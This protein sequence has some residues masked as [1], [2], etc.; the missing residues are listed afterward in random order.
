MQSLRGKKKNKANIMHLLNLELNNDK[1]EVKL[2]KFRIGNKLLQ[3]FL[4]DFST[5]TF[6]Q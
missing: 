5:N 6:L 4:F 3:K 1:T 2:T